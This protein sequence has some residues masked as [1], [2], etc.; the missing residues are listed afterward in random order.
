[1]IVPASRRK[2]M[3]AETRKE[4]VTNTMLPAI[5]LVAVLLAITFLP[6]LSGS[7]ISPVQNGISHS[8]P[9]GLNP[10]TGG[11]RVKPNAQFPGFYTVTFNESGLPSGTVW[12]VNI[13][14]TSSSGPIT[15]RNYSTT[16]FNGQYSY[17]TS[18]SDGKYR[19]S[20]GNFSVNG[21]AIYRLVNFTQVTY[22]ATFSL[23]NAAFPSGT[24]WYVNL[25]GGHDSGPIRGDVYTVN[26]A[27]GTY[28]YTIETSD[29]HFR[30]S[31][32]SS[33]QGSGNLQI[34]GSSRNFS[35][36]FS[37]VAYDIVIMEHGLPNGTGWTVTT[38]TG[39]NMSSNS[40]SIRIPESN[41]T[42]HFNP[43]NLTDYY[44]DS[45]VLTVMVNGSSTTVNVQY[46]RYAYLRG[47]ISPANA[48]VYVSGKKVSTSNGTFNVTEPAGKYNLI[49]RMPG[50]RQYRGSVNLTSG[51]TTVLNIT[52][53]KGGKSFLTSLGGIFGNFFSSLFNL[54]GINPLYVIIGGIGAACI[55]AGV[56]GYVIGKRYY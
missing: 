7:G 8:Q 5:I 25:S 27:N 48:S 38:P 50:Y 22:N 23:L 52:L 19:G 45:G 15:G 9:K 30:L 29:K 26:I 56:T 12:Y 47:R 14:G 35:L 32:D 39:G 18:T 11:G 42:Y 37:R 3:S 43:R 34:N 33:L 36:V 6:L 4:N 20:G 46:S 53:H 49:V 28:R 10:S 17:A 40:S 44:S 2:G 31:G 54:M 55:V 21:K 1:M 13:T 41:G 24:A 16:L 51:N